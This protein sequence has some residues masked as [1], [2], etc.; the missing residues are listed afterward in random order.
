ME[1]IDLTQTL[2]NTT[3]V[4]PGTEGPKFTDATTIESDGFAVKLISMFSH[5]GTHMDSPSHM[6]KDA[7]SLDEFGIS[8]FT[9]EGVVIDVSNVGRSIDVKHIQTTIGSISS[10]EYVLFHSNWDKKWGDAKY[11]IDFPI[12]TKE[13]ANFLASLNI[14]G[15]GVDCISVDPIG[16][17]IMMNHK[18][19]MK[20]EMVIIE[21]LCSLEYLINR[22]FSFY[23]F[24]LRI[25]NA[26]G[27]PIRAVGM[28]K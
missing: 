12:L 14:K 7:K 9:G 1:I 2:N 20:Q 11:F 6:I 13:S 17:E 22:S 21:N 27:S 26:D 8:K 16:D 28:L 19:L 18:I 15:I 4:Y 5:T 24:P 10:I 25:E 3:P 23:C